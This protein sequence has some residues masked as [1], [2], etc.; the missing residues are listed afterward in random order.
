MTGKSFRTQLVLRRG[1]VRGS[2]KSTEV[3]REFTGHVEIDLAGAS[4]CLQNARHL[5]W[6]LYRSLRRLRGDENGAGLQSR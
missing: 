1:S 4:R 3:I 2:E 6:D 5:D